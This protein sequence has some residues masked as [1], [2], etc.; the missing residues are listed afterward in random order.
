MNFHIS[1]I[2]TVRNASLQEGHG[3]PLGLQ[4]IFRD[5]LEKMDAFKDELSSFMSH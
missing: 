4:F 1:L 5:P 3:E 2:V